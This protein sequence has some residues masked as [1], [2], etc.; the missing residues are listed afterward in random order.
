MRPS[1]RRLAKLG[2]LADKKDDERRAAETIFAATTAGLDALLALNRNRR[3]SVQNAAN[4]QN[5]GRSC[6][7]LR[8]SSR[9][10]AGSPADTYFA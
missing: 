1:A 7:V 9:G 10:G 2:L 6:I 8:G 3:W 5:F 4:F